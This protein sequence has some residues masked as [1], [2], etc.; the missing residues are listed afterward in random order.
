MCAFRDWYTV[1]VADLKTPGD[2]KW[3]G[4]IFLSIEQQEAC[5]PDLALPYDSY[6]RKAYGY[7]FAI[8]HGAQY[9][10]DT[11]D[12]N[13]LKSSPQTTLANS[14]HMRTMISTVASGNPYTAFG[15]AEIWPRGYPLEWIHKKTVTVES[16]SSDLI[17]TNVG[18]VQGL[19][20]LD[21]DLDALFR[22]THLNRIGHI[23]FT[24]QPPLAISN[25]M[26]VP[27]NSQATL[28]HYSAFWGLFLPTTTAFRVC[29]IWRGYWSQRILWELEEPTSLVFTSAIVDQVR[30]AHRYTDDMVQETQL[31]ED[32]GNLVSF[33]KD[34]TLLQ[35]SLSEF[36]IALSTSM[37]HAGFWGWMD[38][39]L[40]KQWLHQL[41]KAGYK[42][43]ARRQS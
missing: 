12:D 21:P 15:Q 40:I 38:V 6:T 3:P 7:L 11:D 37:A 23:Y 25:E 9:L 24:E 27:F 17:K 10:Y 32:A 33:L 13:E 41:N 29:D 19:A 36:I 35:T 43:P 39:Y 26:L 28:F 8:Q 22:L 5:Y 1:V 20:N 4:C 34:F 16:A 2:W 42:F 18:I 14:S 30:N 31:Y